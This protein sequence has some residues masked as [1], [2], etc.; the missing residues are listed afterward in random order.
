MQQEVKITSGQTILLIIGMIL[1]TAML[2]VPSA[3]VKYASTD[4]WVSLLLGTAIGIATALVSSAVAMKNPGLGV[5]QMIELHL[6]R[7]FSKAVQ[8]LF[9]LYWFFTSIDV[10][11]QFMDFMVQ[12]VMKKTPSVALGIIIVLLALYSIYHGLEVIARVNSIVA[13]GG[14]LVFA[15][16]TTFYFQAMKLV[17]LLPL[18][19]APFNKIFMGGY[20]SSSWFT[21]VFA[22]MIFASFLNEPRKT[23]TVALLGISLTGLSMIWIVMGSLA[24]FGDRIIPL[25]DYPTFNV[26]RIIEVARFLERIDA[27]Y[28]AVWVGMMI[29]KMSIVM[30]L[31]FYCFCQTFGIKRQR[32]FL[33]PFGLLTLTYSLVSWG[34]RSEYKKFLGNSISFYSLI[35]LAVPTII[36]ILLRWKQANKKV[37]T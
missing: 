2:T 12:S 19:N 5:F 20:L 16:S 25:F 26:F 30:F 8:I 4:A 17:N 13:I 18:L 24:I 9:S 1:P 29:M 37:A 27:F 32:P 34:D 35:A 11:R 6:G 36:W 3:I 31:G 10:L 21:M 15:V 28:I 14:F 23:R 7:Y 33:I 22:I